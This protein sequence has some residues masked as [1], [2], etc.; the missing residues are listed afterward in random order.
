MKSIVRMMKRYINMPLKYALPLLFICALVLSATTGCTT[1]QTT[2]SAQ[3]ATGQQQASDAMSVTVKSAGSS[4]QVGSFNTPKA[5]YKYVLYNTTVKN[6][7]VKSQG[8]SPG[9]FTLRLSNGNVTNVDSAMYDPSIN[10]L[11]NVMS[12]QPGDVVSGVI[13]FQIPTDATPQSIVYNDISHK[14]T[15]N[16]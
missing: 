10:G 16:L 8:I 1:Q 9:F 2:Q 7:N 6:N 15:T 11:Q 14:I 3:N 13:I 5:G 4:M 12:S